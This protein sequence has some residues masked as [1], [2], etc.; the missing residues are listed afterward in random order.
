MKPQNLIIMAVVTLKYLSVQTKDKGPKATFLAHEFWLK[1]KNG[2]YLI[3]FIIYIV[4]KNENPTI[5]Q[6]QLFFVLS[7]VVNKFIFML[8]SLFTANQYFMF[9][10]ADAMLTKQKDDSVSSPNNSTIS[11]SPS[12]RSSKRRESEDFKRH[13]IKVR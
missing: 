8:C 9:R 7:T 5:F 6:L 2:L 10:M 1:M 4:S 13:I 12:R 3:L 11:S